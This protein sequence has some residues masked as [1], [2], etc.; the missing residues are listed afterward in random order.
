MKSGGVLFY[1]LSQREG[2]TAHLP[3]CEIISVLRIFRDALS[4]FDFYYRLKFF[5]TRRRYF[6]SEI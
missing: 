4:F 2:E 3:H 6:L 1:S 5:S